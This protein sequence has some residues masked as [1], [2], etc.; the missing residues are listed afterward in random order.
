MNDDARN[1]ERE[2]CILLSEIPMN[3]CQ[4]TISNR[5]V[6]FLVYMPVIE[7]QKLTTF[8]HVLVPKLFSPPY[9]FYPRL[10]CKIRSLFLTLFPILCFT[11]I[12]IPFV[13]FRKCLGRLRH[14]YV[15]SGRG[16]VAHNLE[17]TTS[18]GI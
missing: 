7:Y 17:N 10:L 1:H 12:F 18:Y 5:I 4:G 16:G 14:V 8:G 11:I 6:V 13:R 9:C 15:W 2:D 3:F